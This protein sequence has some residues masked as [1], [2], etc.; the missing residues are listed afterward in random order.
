M[1]FKSKIAYNKLKTVSKLTDIPID[2]IL[3]KKDSVRDNELV[4]W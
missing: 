4:C 1:L 2:L 3:N